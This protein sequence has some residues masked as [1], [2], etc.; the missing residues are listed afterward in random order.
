ML[1]NSNKYKQNTVSDTVAPLNLLTDAN[2][3][4]NFIF[5]MSSFCKNLNILGK[6]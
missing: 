6:T 3:L 4:S 5:K 2:N 1:T